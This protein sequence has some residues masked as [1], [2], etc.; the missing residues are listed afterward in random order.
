MGDHPGE[1]L[2][3]PV[4]AH[5]TFHHASDG[6]LLR[7]R[8]LSFDSTFS[9]QNTKAIT[10]NINSKPTTIPAQ[11]GV[12]TFDDTKDYWFADDGHGAPADHPGRYEP[13]WNS[14]RVP[15]TGTTI[16]IKSGGPQSANM[17]VVVAPK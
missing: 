9:K 11:A 5:P 10:V 1:G 15:K 2:L 17:Q 8:I 12:D 7:P 6:T 14:V 3:L 13:E 16:S 4:D